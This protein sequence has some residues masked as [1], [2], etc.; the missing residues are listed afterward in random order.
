MADTLPSPPESRSPSP[1]LEHNEN[2]DNLTR[3]LDTLLEKYLELLDQYTALREEL[4]KTFSAGF[5]SLAQAQR[6]STLGAGRRYGEECYD[7]RMKAQRRVG[8]SEDETD[9]H[10]VFKVDKVVRVE[11]EKNS[12]SVEFST[13]ADESKP[14]EQAGRQSL[15][16]T[17]EVQGEQQEKKLRP[18]QD[19]A[20]RDPVT[21]F[22]ILVPPALRQTQS[23]FVK[24]T[25]KS[26]PELLSIDSAMKSVEAE[27]WAVRDELGMLADYDENAETA[28]HA[29]KQTEHDK[30]LAKEQ[31]YTVSRRKLAS[32][33]AHSKSHLVQLSE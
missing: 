29:P 33:P 17:V 27:I 6:A 31:I 18:K 19:P 28:K 4:S 2:E 22:G 15:Q 8:V 32:R 11:K 10:H 1:E 3:K 7:E 21:W 20:H 16:A 23:H 9:E 13:S 24:A 26:I 12:I 25:E 30:Q 5:F 14:Q